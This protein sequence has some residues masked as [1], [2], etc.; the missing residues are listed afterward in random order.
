MSDASTLP[1]KFY[2]DFGID[3]D[4]FRSAF[5]DAGNAMYRLKLGWSLG[6]THAVLTTGDKLKT[7]ASVGGHPLEARAAGELWKM[8]TKGKPVTEEYCCVHNCTNPNCTPTSPQKA[9]ATAHVYASFQTPEKDIRFMILLPTCSADNHAGKCR[10]EEV[11]F[12][13]I[14]KDAYVLYTALSDPPP[15]D[16]FIEVSDATAS[17]KGSKGKGTG[18]GGGLKDD[19]FPGPPVK[20]KIA[21]VHK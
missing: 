21:G 17:G 7:V 12:A 14:G 10:K 8:C 19:Y 5:Q 20:A 16:I 2:K 18:K 6:F 11:N 1:T 3:P 4:S 9:G 15:R 13:E